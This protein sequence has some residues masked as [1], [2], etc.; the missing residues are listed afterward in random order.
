MLGGQNEIVSICNR[1]D[2][3]G[4]VSLYTFIEYRGFTN[5]IFPYSYFICMS[6]HLVLYVNISY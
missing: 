4:I 2:E 1:R 5:D 6:D 3:E